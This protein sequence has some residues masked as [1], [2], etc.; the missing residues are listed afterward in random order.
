MPLELSFRE[1]AST[2][3]FKDVAMK[4]CPLGRLMAQTNTT[5]TLRGN[6]VVDKQGTDLTS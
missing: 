4:P 3:L 6:A 1:Q 5:H 2:H